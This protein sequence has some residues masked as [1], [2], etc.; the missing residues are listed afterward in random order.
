M[1]ELVIYTK[2]GCPYCKAA[3]EQFHKQGVPYR[4]INVSEDSGALQY[5]RETFGAKKVPV[6]V[7]DGALV[8][9]GFQGGG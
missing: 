3:M 7:R 8:E 9:I 5:I 4:E 6:T 2:T 1:S